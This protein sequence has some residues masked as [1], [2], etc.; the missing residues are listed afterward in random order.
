MTKI[1][2]Q[3]IKLAHECANQSGRIIKR[4]FRKP[5]KIGIKKDSSPVTKADIEVEK[6]IR[7]LIKKK[8][9]NCGWF[10]EETGKTNINKEWVWC[11]D[12][13]DGTRSFITGKPLFGTLIGLLKNNK[14]V[15]GI[16]DQPILKERWVGIANKETKLNNKKVRVKKCKNIK[17]SKMYATSPLMF[18]GKNQK[19]YRNIRKKTGECLFGAD[20]YS[21]GLMASGYVDIIL[22]ANLKPYDYIAS[23]AI[24]SGAGGTITDWYGKE[25]NINSDGRILATGDPKIH[26]QLIK[27]IQK[28]K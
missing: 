10:G 22:E 26:K 27:A 28:V 1:P 17:G 6:V 16:L 25:L 7:N 14:P 13:I 9:P 21:H 15:F 3:F 20:C 24:I 4:Y 8:A 12:P 5:L 19:V 18:K 23:A 2:Y 11:V